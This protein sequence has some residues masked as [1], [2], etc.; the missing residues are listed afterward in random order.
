MT[1]TQTKPDENQLAGI[2]SI[3]TCVKSEAEAL[4]LP[5]GAAVGDTWGGRTFSDGIAEIL[6][7]RSCGGWRDVSYERK[8][9]TLVVLAR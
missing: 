5:V 2:R 6:E 3:V 7:S 8:R 9:W 4:A 1:Q